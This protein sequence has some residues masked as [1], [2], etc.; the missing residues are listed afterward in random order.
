MSEIR[1]TS[2]FDAPTLKLGSAMHMRYRHPVFVVIRYCYLALIPIGIALIL[3]GDPQFGILCILVGPILFLRKVF[4]QYRLIAGSKTS[5]QAGQAL[6]WS[7]SDFGVSQ[8]SE[9]HEKDF[10]WKDFDDRYLSP[11]GILFYL[12]K[13]QYF[14]LP[15]SAF[16]TQE[17]FEKVSRLCE[18]KIALPGE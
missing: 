5:P 12:S 9:V 11:K 2:Y 14:I 7:F 10:S 4:W 18:T 17:D 8:K 16:S 15:R 13:D 3:A 1:A 6:N